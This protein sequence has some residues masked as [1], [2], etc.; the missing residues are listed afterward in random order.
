MI[1][2]KA[3]G[4]IETGGV[5]PV[6]DDDSNENNDGALQPNVN[7]IV[8]Y[9]ISTFISLFQIHCRPISVSIS[10]NLLSIKMKSVHRTKPISIFNPTRVPQKQIKSIVRR[11]EK[12]MFR[13]S[14]LLHN[15]C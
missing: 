10:P 12:V 9:R 4:D 13:T 11:T 2:D 14:L 15:W 6:G 8:A 1:D 5:V 3:D 7:S